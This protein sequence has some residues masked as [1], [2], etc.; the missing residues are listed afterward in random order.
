MI[1]NEFVMKC[2]NG[3][4]LFFVGINMYGYYNTLN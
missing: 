3:E 2:E 4:S 1:I